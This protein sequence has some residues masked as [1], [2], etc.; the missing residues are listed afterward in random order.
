MPFIGLNYFRSDLI[1]HFYDNP[2]GFS[3]ALTDCIDYNILIIY[4]VPNPKDPKFPTRA[5][6]LNR[7]SLAVKKILT[8]LN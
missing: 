7:E 4:H 6:K 8:E 2:V 3:D 1:S 5:C